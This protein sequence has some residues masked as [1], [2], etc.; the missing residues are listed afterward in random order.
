MQDIFSS[1][2][3]IFLITMLGS[4]IKSKWITSE[5]FWRGIEKLSYFLLFP[6]LLF[7]YISEADLSSPELIRLIFG[8]IL[9]SCIIGFA[10]V[11]YQRQYDVDKAQFTSIFQG[12]IRYN[13]Y[14]FFA[15]GASLYGP[16][17]ME[18]V[19]VV[20]AYMIIFTNAASIFV[21]A[22]YIKD[23]SQTQPN[24]SNFMSLLRK[25]GVN[26]LIIASIIGF[27]FNY[28]DFQLNMG[29]KNTLTSLSN[30]ALAIGIMNVGAG[31]KFSLDAEDFKHV[32]ISCVI[33]L[34]VFPLISM[35]VL[36]MMSITGTQKAIGILYSGLP[37]ASTSYVLAKQLGG[38]SD[39]MA[40]IITITTILSVF[41]LSLIMYIST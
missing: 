20:S 25:F 16:K 2:L 40:S 12:S 9:V 11:L 5:E 19:A 22:T 21:F 35:A 37:A 39:L 28:S 36:S 15:L 7:N 10:L 30:S 33:K 1:I 29:I 31:L 41:T 18:V 3:P 27:I 34:L 14:T 6:I 13:S 17:G 8:L 32:T 26:P 24:H 23:G 38:D 4:I